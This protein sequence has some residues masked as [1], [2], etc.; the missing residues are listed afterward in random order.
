MNFG[1][2]IR[3][4]RL[5]SE[6]ISKILVQNPI[7]FTLFSTNK[8]KFYLVIRRKL[9]IHRFIK[10]KGSKCNLDIDRIL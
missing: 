3:F 6:F 2:K 9:E 4:K 10:K 7:A 1:Q 5:I 8:K